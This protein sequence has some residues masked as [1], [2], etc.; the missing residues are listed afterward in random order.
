MLRI[1]SWNCRSISNKGS[2]IHHLLDKYDPELLCLQETHSAD[3]LSHP[4]Y[5]TYRKDRD[6]RGGG[7]ITLVKKSLSHTHDVMSIPSNDNRIDAL[8]VELSDAVDPSRNITVFNVYAPPGTHIKTDELRLRGKTVFA[9]DFNCHNLVW[10]PKSDRAGS[11]LLDWSIA[12][13]LAVANT[14]GS[15]TRPETN[16]SPDVIFYHSSMV[17]GEFKLLTE[18]NSSDH[19]PLMV[20]LDTLVPLS[21]TTNGPKKRVIW[22]FDSANWTAFESDLDRRTR[23]AKLSGNIEKDA[24]LFNNIL[25]EVGKKHIRRRVLVKGKRRRRWKCHDTNTMKK[26]G[27]HLKEQLFKGDGFTYAFKKIKELERDGGVETVIKNTHVQDVPDAFLDQFVP[28]SDPVP[29]LPPQPLESDTNLEISSDFTSIEL[30][31]AIRKLKTGKAA[32][33][34]GIHNRL[35]KNMPASTR[36]LLLSIIN[37]TWHSSRVP[38]TWKEG[39]IKPMKKPG[40]PRGELGSYRPI[41]LT[42]VVGKLAERLVYDRLVYWLTTNSA[43][44]Q[45]QAGFRRGRNTCEQITLLINAMVKSDKENK[46]VIFLSFDFS[47]AFDRIN[48]QKLLVKLGRMGVPTSF[49]GWISSFLTKRVVRV[50][51]NGMFS[52]YRTQTKGVPQGSILGPLLY[53]IYVNDLCEVV[54]TGER[55]FLT[56]ALYADDTA[57]VVTG[58]THERAVQNA[59][60]I[61]DDVDEWCHD[62]DMLLSVSKTCAMNVRSD[63]RMGLKF[64]R[65]CR[66]I[67]YNLAPDEDPTFLM[68]DKPSLVT[69]E[70]I[71]EVNGVKVSTLDDVTRGIYFDGILGY[72]RAVTGCIKVAHLLPET[73]SIRYLGVHIDSDLKFGNQVKKIHEVI[74]KGISLLH[75]LTPYHLDYRT[76]QMV[77][78]L[79]ICSRVT[80]GLESFGWC[81][82]KRDV[83]AIN[84]ELRKVARLVT[85]C[86]ISTPSGPLMWEAGMMPFELLVSKQTWIAFYRYLSL[87][88]VPSTRSLMQ[89]SKTVPCWAA[90]IPIRL[91]EEIGRSGYT[92]LVQPDTVK[93]WLN[94]STISISNGYGHP[95]S[96]DPTLD[97]ARFTAHA[98]SLLPADLVVYTDGSF[99]PRNGDAG[100][101]YIV[102]KGQEVIAKGFRKL[103]MIDSSYGAEQA[104]MRMVANRI[105]SSYSNVKSIRVFTDSKSLLDELGMGISYQR[106]SLSRAI[107]EDLQVSGVKVHLQFIPSH[108]GVEAHD[109]VDLMANHAAVSGNIKPF[110]IPRDFF[111]HRSRVKKMLKFDQRR[112]INSDLYIRLVRK[113]KVIFPSGME[114]ADEIRV[115]KFRTGDHHLLNTWRK[116]RVCPFC[117]EK[118]SPYHLLMGCRSIDTERFNCLGFSLTRGPQRPLDI[119]FFDGL[120]SLEDLFKPLW[121]KSTAFFIKCM[122]SLSLASV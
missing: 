26:K 122:E 1:L 112:K 23:R 39:L 71:L 66:T 79:Y 55:S 83:E 62:N 45:I 120:P 111:T 53:L 68:P 59:Q 97:K 42:S 77:K 104:A 74:K 15:V 75:N 37:N 56:S 94:T 98:M 82:R 12:E 52:K 34:D 109:E 35:L 110:D 113:S 41:T 108:V 106:K 21:V 47:S 101:A 107:L 85:G 115:S 32:G 87:D 36:G 22:D 46:R 19:T 28:A 27:A 4:D 84:F 8:K 80:Y 117:T 88:W 90:S 5:Y 89:V 20:T 61:L 67:E 105:R 11:R 121:L 99:H 51:A 14:P 2:D 50:E 60:R 103:K 78:E 119:K 31:N 13:D 43:L 72:N 76:L 30:D 24:K 73:D 48:H 40:K 64:S 57:C 100:A 92:R 38:T 81:L 10:S 44:D 17:L 93:P 63:E 96:G 25:L 114:R 86:G 58:D 49:I 16:T 95:K 7:V 3:Q 9:G 29:L 91:R 54:S 69:G 65:S 118:S 18:L 33:P 6:G 70:T 116:E 102:L